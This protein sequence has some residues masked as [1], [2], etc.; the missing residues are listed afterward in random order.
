M[1]RFGLI[2]N[3]S[4]G[5]RYIKKKNSSKGTAK[6]DEQG[7]KIKKDP[8]NVHFSIETKHTLINVVAVLP[9]GQRNRIHENC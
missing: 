9:L 3:G 4:E 2:K 1:K 5:W 8:Q 7:L 6:L